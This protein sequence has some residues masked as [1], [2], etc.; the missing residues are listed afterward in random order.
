MASPVVR[1]I[2]NAAHI[3]DEAAR[4]IRVVLDEKHDDVD[5]VTTGRK[6]EFCSESYYE[7][8]RI[9]DQ[10]WNEKWYALERSLKEEARFFSRTAATHLG[11]LFDQIDSMSTSDGGPL[12]IDA[13]P[14]TSLSALYRARSFQSDDPLK[15]A[16]REPDQQLGPPPASLASAGRMNA[17]G[18]SVFYGANEPDVAIAE[19]RPPVGSQVAVARF[20][21]IRPLR[22]LDLTALRAVS[23]HGSIFDP[24]LADRMELAMFLPSL[25]RRITQPVMPDD[26]AFDYLPTQAIADFLATESKSP[27]DGI[28]FPSVQATDAGQNVV[29]FHKAARVEVI[30]GAKIEATISGQAHD[31]GF[32]PEYAMIEQVPRKPVRPLSSTWLNPDSRE[33]ALRIDINSIK[34]HVVHGVKFCTTEHHV[35]RYPPGKTR[36][37]FLGDVAL[38]AQ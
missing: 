10:A 21:I 9:S 14:G 13:G 15:A 20:E 38:L 4:D 16:L 34:V 12:V 6:T 29:L 19:V 5:S 32:E 24:S 37:P 3:P 33:P 2:A 18:I 30:E 31:E 35:V 7:K 8:K 17:R 11:S 28:V 1:A 23:E 25:S 26:E 22:L 27:I 36:A